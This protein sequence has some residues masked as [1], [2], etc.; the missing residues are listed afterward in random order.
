[1]SRFNGAAAAARWPGSH[2]A[3]GGGLA[4]FIVRLI[5]WHELWRLIRYL[6]RIPTF[7]PFIVIAIVIML[8]GLA[9]WRRRRGPRQ[10]RAS[11]AGSTGYGTGTGPRDW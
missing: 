6:W 10:R 5:I 1:V 8:A 11:S 4:H 7:G 9:V 2:L 3:L